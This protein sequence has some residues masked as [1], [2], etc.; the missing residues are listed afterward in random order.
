MAVIVWKWCKKHKD[1]NPPTK[2]V[3]KAVLSGSETNLRWPVGRWGDETYE[4]LEDDF[5]IL[6]SPKTNSLPLKMDGWKI[7]FLCG[8]VLFSGD[9]LGL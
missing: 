8:E 1:I 3:A 4:G 6:P 9:M 5:P 7:V 2:A